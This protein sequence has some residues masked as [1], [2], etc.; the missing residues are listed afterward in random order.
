M[1]DGG[2][3]NPEL[4]GAEP[5]TA[6]DEPTEAEG[7]MGGGRWVMLDEGVGTC[8]NAR[9]TSEEDILVQGPE[10]EGGGVAPSSDLTSCKENG[11]PVRSSAISFNE[12]TGCIC[13]LSGVCDQTAFRCSG[14]GA[15]AGD[16]CNNVGGWDGGDVNPF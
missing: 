8:W 5:F 7:T 6:V 15:R 3:G 2:N 16:H 13:A 9:V 10:L 11:T 12:L 1:G 14:S 4:R